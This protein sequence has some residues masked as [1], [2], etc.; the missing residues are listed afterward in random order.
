[1]P[2]AHVRIALRC[3]AGSAGSSRNLPPDDALLVGEGGA[4]FR[5]PHGT[6]IG[7]ERRRPLA[8]LLHR[9]ASERLANPGRALAW[10]ALLEAGWPD[11]RVVA[12]AG[13]HRV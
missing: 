7:L 5:L 9:L 6:R 2:S 1:I 4:W 12:D 11:E 8:K 3:I 13:A 10:H